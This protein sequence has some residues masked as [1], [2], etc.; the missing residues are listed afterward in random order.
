MNIWISIVAL[1]IIQSNLVNARK[2]H[3]SRRGPDYSQKLSD[4]DVDEPNF[5]KRYEDL[6]LTKRRDE[7][8]SGDFNKR[9]EE[10]ALTKRRD[11]RG[12]KYEEHIEPGK[13]DVFV[14]SSLFLKKVP[15]PV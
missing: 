3:L 1:A 4:G 7:R 14:C 15:I 10:P 12:Q 2:V 9:Y 5:N 13:L 8:G 11:K 6:A